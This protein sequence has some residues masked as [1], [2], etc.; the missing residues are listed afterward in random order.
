VYISNNVPGNI[1]KEI[2][3]W[4][5]NSGLKE[6]YNVKLFDFYSKYTDKNAFPAVC[7]QA[8]K[9]VSPFASTYLCQQIFQG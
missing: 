8:M 5:C 1:Q 9:M 2:A 7:S 6:K 4:Q 3:N